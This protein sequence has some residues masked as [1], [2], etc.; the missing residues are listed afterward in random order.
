MD[1][2]AMIFGSVAELRAE[3]DEAR[4][5]ASTLDNTASIADLFKYAASLETDADFLSE[6]LSSTGR[7][8]ARVKRVNASKLIQLPGGFGSNEQEDMAKSQICRATRR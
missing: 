4:H 7:T 2:Q 6:S 5:L 3:A 1:H 8:R